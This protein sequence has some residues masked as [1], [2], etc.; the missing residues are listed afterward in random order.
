ML[1]VIACGLDNVAEGLFQGRT[2]GE[3]A[4]MGFL[5]FSQAGQVQGSCKAWSSSVTPYL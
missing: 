5:L 1:L 3:G 4:Q 2:D